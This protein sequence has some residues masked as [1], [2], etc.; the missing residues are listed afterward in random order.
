MSS[1]DDAHQPHQPDHHHEHV[2]TGEPVDE[3][4]PDEPRTPG[5]LP[6]LGVVLFTLAAVVLL[7]S[8]TNSGAT[9]GEGDG[10]GE[11]AV[12]AAPTPTPASPPAP[13]ATA[14]HP[15]AQQAGV[16][17]KLVQPAH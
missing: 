13:P 10:A 11:H 12:A 16:V 4:P 1:A 17:K 15:S 7:V 14:V 8:R 2:F 5:W 6:V 9:T 3:L